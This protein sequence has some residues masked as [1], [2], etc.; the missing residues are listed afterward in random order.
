MPCRRP[1]EVAANAAAAVGLREGDEL[2][3]LE[4]TFLISDREVVV[5]VKRSGSPV[6]IRYLP[7]R[8]GASRH[9]FAWQRK[10]CP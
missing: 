9:G 4:S 2:V 10:P 6:T 8:P 7:A 1:A 5:T 3:A